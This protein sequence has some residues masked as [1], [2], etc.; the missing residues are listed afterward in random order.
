MSAGALVQRRQARPRVG[1]A[2]A[3][4]GARRARAT[5]ARAAPPPGAAARAASSQ[6]STSTRSGERGEQ[7]VRPGRADLR[8]HVRA[9]RQQVA[10][11]RLDGQQR[12]GEQR[13]PAGSLSRTASAR[14]RGDEPDGHPG[15]L[16]ATSGGPGP[17]RLPCWSTRSSATPCRWS[18]A[19]CGPGQVLY[20]EAGKFLFR[21]GDVTM[22]TKLTQP[23][24]SAAG[25]GRRRLGRAAARRARGRQADGGRGV[26][27]LPA[28]HDPRRRR[29]GRARRGPARRDAGD[30]GTPGQTWLAEKDAFVGAEGTV[31]FDVAF[32]GLRTGFSGGE[33]FVLEKFTS[34]DRRHA[35]HRRRR[36]LHRHQPGGVRRQAVRRHRLHRRLRGRPSAT[37]SSGSAASTGPGIMNAAFGGEGLSQATL[38]GDGQVS[39]SA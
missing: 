9:R 8:R 1:R 22:E 7:R 3:G 26:V 25:R 20:A 31:R 2:P 12:A 29:P 34:T 39:C 37:P 15:S 35:V 23:T 10:V 19:R 18:C 30:R 13:A 16:P 32:C 24:S 33:G 27:R 5:P 38:E 14:V 6:T 4:V 21:S 36:Q 11:R 28:L 17:R